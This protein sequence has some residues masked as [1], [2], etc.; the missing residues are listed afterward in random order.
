LLKPNLITNF[1]AG[2]DQRTTAA[3]DGA[4]ATDTAAQ[5]K[6]Q[7]VDQ[8][9]FITIPSCSA[10]FDYS[11]LVVNEAFAFTLLIELLQNLGD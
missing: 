7:L 9:H 8:T 10:W 6:S 11:Q 2:S 3:A 4:P 5:S 1:S